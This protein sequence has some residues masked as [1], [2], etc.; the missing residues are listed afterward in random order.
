MRSQRLCFAF[1]FCFCSLART[2]TLEPPCF[3]FFEKKLILMRFFAKRYAKTLFFA[4]F[5]TVFSYPSKNPF[6]AIRIA[7]NNKKSILKKRFLR[8][9]VRFGYFSSFVFYCA[10][11]TKT[12]PLKLNHLYNI[13]TVC[14]QKSAVCEKTLLKK[15]FL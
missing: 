12:H 6:F 10:R 11:F 15:A 5:S 1:H 9:F 8:F 7:K 13:K 14:V 2:L 3:L 4:S